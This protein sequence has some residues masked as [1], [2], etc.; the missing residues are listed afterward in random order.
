MVLSS[1]GMFPVSRRAGKTSKRNSS[2][3]SFPEV[4]MAR[5]WEA[6]GGER[7]SFPSWTAGECV[8]GQVAELILCSTLCFGCQFYFL[9]CGR[10]EG[11]QL[12]EG[13]GVF[14]GLSSPEAFTY[15]P[16]F[17]LL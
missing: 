9:R 11:K 12:D 6:A 14:F 15:L 13:L 7:A 17:P 1:F 2:S 10:C 3:A 8:A 4:A 16:V 5:L